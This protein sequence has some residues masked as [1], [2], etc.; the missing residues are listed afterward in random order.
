MIYNSVAGLKAKLSALGLG[1]WVFG[2][3]KWWGEQKDDVS[4]AVMAAAVTAGVNLFDTAPFYGFGHSEKLTGEFIAERQIRKKSIISTKL[5]L[6]PDAPG[7]HNLKRDRMKK[8]IEES[9]SRLGTDYIDIYHIHWP[10]PAVPVEESAKTMRGFYEEGLIRSVGVSNYSVAEMRRFMDVCPL[11][12][13]QPPYSMF[14]RSIE[15]EL[16]PFCV[17][18]GVSVL[19]YSPLHGGMLTGKF[20]REGYSPPRDLRRKGMKDLREPYYSVEKDAFVKTEKLADGCGISPAAFALAW[21]MSRKGVASVLMGA[22]NTAQLEENLKSVEVILD[23][24][25]LLQ[26]DKILDKMSADLTDIDNCGTP[27]YF[28]KSADEQKS[29][30]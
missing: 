2:G 27:S 23:K 14:N 7:F 19:A 24:A 12:F 13:L 20:F 9:L 28:I 16:L 17:K 26:A 22:R 11:H 10:D 15:K 5:G 6:D 21:L 8:E 30:D 18:N 29:F 25:V 3:G 4:K 1:T